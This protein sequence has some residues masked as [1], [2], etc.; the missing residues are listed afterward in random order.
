ML[1]FLL[2]FLKD[3]EIDV[4]PS[5]VS[6]YHKK[7]KQG[8]IKDRYCIVITQISVGYCCVKA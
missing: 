8:S 7:F 5:V 4:P 6:Y 1:M 2:T 3:S